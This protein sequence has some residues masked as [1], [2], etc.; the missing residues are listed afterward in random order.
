M[1]TLTKESP[2]YAAADCSARR[3]VSVLRAAYGIKNTDALDAFIRMELGLP[4]ESRKNPKLRN[5]PD[6]DAVDA[7]AAN[8]LVQ[9]IMAIADR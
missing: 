1:P 2:E 9:K 5:E 8:G 7:E 3:L 6:K 4:S